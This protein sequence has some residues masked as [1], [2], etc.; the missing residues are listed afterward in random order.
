[1]IVAVALLW[2]FLQ[3][4]TVVHLLCGRCIFISDFGLDNS[5]SAS[6]LVMSNKGKTVSRV[7]TVVLV[8]TFSISS[9]SL[10]V[11]MLMPWAPSS[12]IQRKFPARLLDRDCHGAL[13][14]VPH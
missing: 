5:A 14:D 2:K 1:M 7:P 12:S 6:L 3:F 8:N 11:V 4:T 10:K 13:L 9:S